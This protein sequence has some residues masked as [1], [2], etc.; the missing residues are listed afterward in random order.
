MKTRDKQILLR[1]KR[2]LGY[3]EDVLIQGY[4]NG[5]DR[6]E[7]EKFCYYIANLLSGKDLKNDR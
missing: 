4:E 6:Q 1:I 2:C 7:L 3:M 5:M